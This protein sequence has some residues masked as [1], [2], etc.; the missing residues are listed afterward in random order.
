[1]AVTQLPAIAL[2]ILAREWNQ[3]GAH[4]VTPIS[5]AVVRILVADDDRVISQLICAVVREAGHTPIPVFDAMQAL[6]FAMRSPSPDC[7]ILDINM[8]GGTGIEALRKLKQSARTAQIPVIVITGSTDA[9]VEDQV[10][11]LGAE[12]YIGK[13]V[14]PEALVVA[15][16]KALGQGEPAPKA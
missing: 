9:G 4:A 10:R 6:M 13:P 15:I 1:V 14:V 16:R 7:I 8:P 12:T 2:A 11:Q 5:N 3:S